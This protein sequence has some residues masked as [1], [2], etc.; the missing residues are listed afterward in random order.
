MNKTPFQKALSVNV[1]SSIQKN[2]KPE[3]NKPIKKRYD[4][5]CDVIREYK[6]IKVTLTINAEVPWAWKE[7]LLL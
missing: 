3:S 1:Q 4:T 6:I 2:K 7:T 5:Q